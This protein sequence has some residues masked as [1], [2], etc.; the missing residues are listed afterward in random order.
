MKVIIRKYKKKDL[1]SLNEILKE[2]YNLEK[3]GRKSN[4]IEL[5]AWCDEKVVGYLVVNR[6]YD[7][8]NGIYYFH[9]NY[10]CVRSEYRNQGIATKLLQEVFKIAKDK[11]ISYIELTSNKKREVAQHLYQKNGFSIRDTNVFRKEIL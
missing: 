8:I 6:N 4:N 3:S 5:V 2:S 1:D 9:I 11:N 10:V 7:S